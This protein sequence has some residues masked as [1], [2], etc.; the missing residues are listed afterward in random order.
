MSQVSSGEFEFVTAL[1]DKGLK[2][3]E[4]DA[5]GRG[6]GSVWI[7]CLGERR[8]QQSG[9]GT[10]KEHRNAQALIGE[11]VAMGLFD[12]ADQAMQPQTTQ[13][14]AHAPGTEMV[15]IQ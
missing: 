13:V 11:F 2:T 7:G 4:G 6:A 14:V 9:I 1:I 15:R 5:Q 8:A 3:I 12:T 10:G